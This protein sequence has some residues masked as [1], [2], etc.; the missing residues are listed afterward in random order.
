VLQSDGSYAD[1]ISL[2]GVAVKGLT[3]KDIGIRSIEFGG[4]DVQKASAAVNKQA[5]D[6]AIT[7]LKNEGATLPLGAGAKVALVSSRKAWTDFFNPR[8]YGDSASLGDIALI[9]AGSGQVRFSNNTEPYAFPLRDALANRGFDV[10]DWK[11]DAGVYGGN[12]DQF[13]AAFTDNP[14]ANGNSK[15][16][17]SEE[18]AKGMAAELAAYAASGATAT[19]PAIIAEKTANAQ[20]A[21]TAAAAEA[22]V[23]I[24]VFS[25]IIGEGS[26]LNAAQW[27]MENYE[28]IV[29]EAYA[30]AF[31]AANKKMIAL[32]NYGSSV[33]MTAYMGKADAILHVWLPGTDGTFAIADILKG[34]VNPSARLAQSFPISYSDSPSVASAKPDAG[35]ND[36]RQTVNGANAYYDEGVY[37]GYRYYESNPETYETMVAYP[38]GYGLSYT[39]FTYSGFTLDKPVFDKGNPDDKI[40]A[41][42]TVTNTGS[43]AGKEVVQ[44][45]LSASSWEDEGRPKNELKAYAKTK[46]LA[47]DESETV[48]LELKLRDLQYYDDGNDGQIVPNA[49]ERVTYGGGDGWTV[50]DGT[51]FTAMVR[52]N[53]SDAEKPNSPF[54]GLTQTFAYGA[55]AAAPQHTVRFDPDGGTPAPAAQTIESGGFVAQPAVSKE[56]YTLDGWYRAADF[57]GAKW[58]FAADAVNA[59]LTLY[60]KWVEG[61]GPATYTVTFDADGGT[62][63]PAAQAIEAGRYASAPADPAKPLYVFT[64]WYLGDAAAPFNFASVPISADITLKAR[65]RSATPATPSSPGSSSGAG[66]IPDKPAAAEPGAAADGG[67]GSPSTTAPGTGAGGTLSSFSDAAAVAEWARGYFERLVALGVISGRTDGTLD[68]KG[69]VTRAEF[70]KMVVQALNITAAGAPKTFSAD[71]KAG[72]WYKQY[73]DIASANDIVQGLSESSFGPNNK[74]TRQDLCVIMHRAL[75]TLGVETPAPGAAAFPD[76]ADV[77]DY[78]KDA[79][80][81]LKQIGIVAGRDDGRFDPRA[82]ATREETAKIICGVVDYAAANSASE[83]A[84][85]AEAEAPASAPAETSGGAID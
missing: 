3:Q 17:F 6:E 38:F 31:H 78:A 42:V 79:V 85:E 47:P 24:F 51:V 57:T 11:I 8:W 7:L 77:A 15:Y 28:K 76:S 74:V 30:D 59:D 70:T 50:A 49:P 20:A 72:D 29:F 54:E 14:P 21:A 75:N 66:S 62:P 12:N 68:P 32:I 2:E 5:A 27:G 39:D 26:D 41:T 71:V 13:L 60:A 46:L 9:G 64:G 63:A 45:Y 73:V 23:G 61:S 40:T 52:T 16:V 10:V 37:V 19:L 67:G 69:D 44:L 83:A 80:N 35:G 53:A 55:S 18:Q 56:G 22:E 36:N 25:R 33:D 82:F 34:A 43:K 48:T 65:W 1:G 58:N 4:S 84:A 81:V